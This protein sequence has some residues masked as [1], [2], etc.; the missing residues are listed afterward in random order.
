MG[1]IDRP[2]KTEVLE[3]ELD[4][5]AEIACDFTR[6][7]PDTLKWRRLDGVNKSYK[8]FK[9]KLKSIIDLKI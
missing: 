3:V 7:Y 2:K 8:T 6:Y 1:I 4:S 9:I 5:T